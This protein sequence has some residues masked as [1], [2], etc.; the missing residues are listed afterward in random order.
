MA[1]H[2]CI[3][4]LT[5]EVKMLRANEQIL[6]EE[7]GKQGELIKEMQTQLQLKSYVHENV[8]CYECLMEPIRTDRF[9]CVTCESDYDL[10]LYCYCRAAAH[11]KTHKFQT[12]GP[13]GVLIARESDVAYF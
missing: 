12:L 7:V 1:G 8:A 6:R 4:S 2:N 10:C 5:A 3:A 11:P 13:L 9:K